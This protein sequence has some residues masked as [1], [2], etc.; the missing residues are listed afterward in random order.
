MK[1]TGLR[2]TVERIHLRHILEALPAALRVLFDDEDVAFREGAAATCFIDE[3]TSGLYPSAAILLVGM[4]CTA[5]MIV[6]VHH[7]VEIYSG[8]FVGILC[9]LIAVML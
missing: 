9:Q 7:P 2:R 4:V 5:R 8:L 3:G 6:S 1:R